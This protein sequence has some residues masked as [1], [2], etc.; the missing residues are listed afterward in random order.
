M[1]VRMLFSL[2]FMMKTGPVNIGKQTNN[3]NRMITQARVVH[4]LLIVEALLRGIS[5]I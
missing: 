2:N 3:N 4:G 1:E 5:Q